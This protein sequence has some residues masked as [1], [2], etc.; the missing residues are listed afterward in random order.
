MLLLQDQGQ[1]WEA[2]L[3]SLLSGL[4]KASKKGVDRAGETATDLFLF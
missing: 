3:L 2:D 1:A 4:T